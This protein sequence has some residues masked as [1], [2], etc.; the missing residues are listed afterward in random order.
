ML[1]PLLRYFQDV[2]IVGK[3]Q[4]LT[5]I[6]VEFRKAVEILEYLLPARIVISCPFDKSEFRDPVASL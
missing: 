3:P 5:L 4:F 1:D 6:R 2:C